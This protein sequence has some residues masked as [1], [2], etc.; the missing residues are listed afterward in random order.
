MFASKARAAKFEPRRFSDP[1]SVHL[2][3]NSPAH[4]VL[5]LS[6]PMALP[7]NEYETDRAIYFSVGIAQI[8]ERYEL[9]ARYA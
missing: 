6:A 2:G 4:I 9:G 1:R 5:A 7:G 3:Q 8:P